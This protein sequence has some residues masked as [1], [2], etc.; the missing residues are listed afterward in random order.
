MKFALLLITFL[1]GFAVQAEV[2]ICA[3]CGKGSRYM[4]YSA[5]NRYFCSERCAKA[6]FGC[7]SCGNIPAGRYMIIMGTTGE[8]RRYCNSCSQHPKCFSCFF[9]A[10]SRKRLSDGRVQCFD[11]SRQVLS[12]P[13]MQKLLTQ[14]R[15]DLAEMHDF[16]PHHRITMRLVSKSALNKISGD[17]SAMGCMKVLVTTKEQ[18]KGVKKKVTKEWN[19]TLYLLDNLPRTIAAKVI[20]GICEAVSGQWLLLK[21]HKGAFETLKK[22]PDPIYGAGFREMYPQLERYGMRGLIKRYRSVFTPF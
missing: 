21:K 14:L 3:H 12:Q 17:T 20:E 4:R 5:E 15:Y 7:F 1:A 9:P 8:N 16:D 10:S 13:E 18:F 11:C 6:K 22:N 19:C 2:K